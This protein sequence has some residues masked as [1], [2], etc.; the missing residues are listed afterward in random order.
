MAFDEKGKFH[1]LHNW[2][3]D[4]I[5]KIKIEAGRKDEEDNGFADGLTRTFLRD[6][7]AKMESNLDVAGHKIVNL[8]QGAL[9]ADAVA[10]KQLNAAVSKADEALKKIAELFVEVEALPAKPDDSV[11]YFTKEKRLYKGSSRIIE[12][13]YCNTALAQTE[14]LHI[15][16]QAKMI[17]KAEAYN[18]GEVIVKQAGAYTYKGKIAKGVFK[19]CV[20][21]AGGTGTMWVANSMG[22]A[23]S[24]GS[25]AAVEITVYNAK[26][27]EIEIYAPPALSGY[28]SQ[29]GGDAFVKIGGVLIAKAKGGIGS[30]A[31]GSYETNT[32]NG[33]VNILLTDAKNGNPSKSGFSGS[34]RVS[35]VSPYD[36]WG[37]ANESSSGSGGMRVEYIRYTKE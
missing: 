16:A 24:G 15:Y 18:P 4:R 5:N 10:Y 20:V 30:G 37:W 21:A 33:V 17:Y 31:G 13:Y 14:I 22:Y 1:R 32:D 8:S 23:N 11:F 35:S 26:A 27:Q 29:T 19:I 9:D 7:R 28:G 3:Q 36:D 34:V 2:K 6:G 12:V 25:G